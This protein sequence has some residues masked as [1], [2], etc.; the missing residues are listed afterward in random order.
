[1]TIKN[2]TIL[3][4]GLI[5]LIILCGGIM[6]YQLIK[7][8]IDININNDS[9]ITQKYNIDYNTLILKATDYFNN[10]NKSYIKRPYKESQPESQIAE[11]YNIRNIKLSEI[12]LI[13]YPLRADIEFDYSKKIILNNEIREKVNPNKIKILLYDTENKKW[14]EANLSWQLIP[15]IIIALLLLISIVFNFSNKKNRISSNN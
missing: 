5:F 4:S 15:L 14:I 9:L 2:K 3:I 1:M 10:R 8:D 7:P 6:Y 12:G 13:K 11:D